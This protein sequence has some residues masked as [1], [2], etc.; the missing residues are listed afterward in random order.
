[1]VFLNYEHKLLYLHVT[2]AYGQT[3]KATLESQMKNENQ[4]NVPR[5]I[6]DMCQGTLFQSLFFHFDGKDVRR[7]FP[8]ANE[9]CHTFM[10]V[11]NPYDRAYSLHQ[12][13]VHKTETYGW[14]VYFCILV[15]A[16]ITISLIF[17]LPLWM[18]IAIWM[19]LLGFITYL[20][21]V[22][23]A[24]A[25]IRY[26]TSTFEKAMAWMPSLVKSH[27]SIFGPQVNYCQGL[28]VDTIL[29]EEDFPQNFKS[30]LQHLHIEA[31]VITTNVGASGHG[32]LTDDKIMFDGHAYRYLD[33]HT[34]ETIRIINTV[35]A[36]D[37]DTFG[38]NKITTTP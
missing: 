31:D 38:F 23:N 28:R 27:S 36:D 1:M 18:C 5:M 35:Y 6:R 3:I 33:K 10:S 9:R 4:P 11:R 22:N 26:N 8:D 21:I 34:P 12:Y 30:M 2:K 20:M 29:H 13:C 14:T 25:F 15:L 24:F 7:E 16:I 32:R 17:V 19:M 37:F